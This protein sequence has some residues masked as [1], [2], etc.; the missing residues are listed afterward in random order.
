MWGAG[1]F[2]FGTYR[3]AHAGGRSAD[4]PL[5]AF[6]PRKSELTLYLSHDFEAYE[7]LMAR[8]GTFKTGK[9]CLYI[10]RLG[11][12]DREVLAGLIDGA[13]AARDP[14]RVRPGVVA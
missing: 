7:G 3:L 2:G 8:L 12:F 13:V 11:G 10:R 6:A 1:I 4:W 9:G 5:I 14:S